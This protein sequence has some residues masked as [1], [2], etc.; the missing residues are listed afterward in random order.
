M[1]KLLLSTLAAVMVLAAQLPAAN[2]GNGLSFGVIVGGDRY[3]Q[4]HYDNYPRPDY[5]WDDDYDEDE[6][7]SCREGKRVVRSHG[8]RQVEAVKCQGNTYRYQAIRRGKLWS[9]RVS[10][11]SGDIVSARAIGYY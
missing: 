2:A 9:V 5:D 6:R 1:K 11:W 10:A 8:Y 3:Q 7:I 4:N